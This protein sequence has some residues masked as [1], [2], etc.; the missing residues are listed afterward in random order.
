[1]SHT[2]LKLDIPIKLIVGV[3]KKKNVFL[4]MNNAF[5]WRD[6]QRNTYK[7][8][9]A[10]LIKPQIDLGKLNDIRNI[11]LDNNSFEI[12]QLPK[13]KRIISIT[14]EV[15]RGDRHSFDVM[16]TVSI[17]DKFFEDALVVNGIITDDNFKVV[18]MVIGM[19]GEYDKS[20]PR[21]SVTIEGK[22]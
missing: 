5:K 10:E 8:A 1:M 22:L 7:Q 2:I 13:L 17:I 12:E 21:V 3:R 16:N 4:S 14:Y 20:N 15:H 18:P 19:I 9:Y 6:V 11:R